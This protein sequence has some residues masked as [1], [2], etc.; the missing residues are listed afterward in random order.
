MTLSIP[1]ISSHSPHSADELL[2]MYNITGQHRET[3][4]DLP[5]R[6]IPETKNI[7]DRFYA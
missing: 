6:T 4:R 2:G 5:D 7:I 3:I 1:R